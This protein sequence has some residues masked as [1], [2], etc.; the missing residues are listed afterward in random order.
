[1]I[2]YMNFCFCISFG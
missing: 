1:M 2:A